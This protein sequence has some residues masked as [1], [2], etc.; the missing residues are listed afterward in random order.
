MGAEL[1]A[2]FVAVVAGASFTASF[3][4]Q[5]RANLRVMTGGDRQGS[6]AV[7]VVRHPDWI[8]GMVLQVVGFGLQALALGIG[9]L[10]VVQTALITE[11][12]FMVPASAWVVQTK[13]VRRDWVGAF[14]VIV[15]LIAFEGLARPRPGLESAPFADWRIPI[16]VC[17]AMFAAL[18]LS[19]E[20]LPSYRA[21]LRGA[22]VGVWG[23]MLGGLVKQLAH[24]VGRGF[25]GLL[26]DW[27][28]WL[29]L[30]VGLVNIL[31]VNL[32]LRA[33]RLESAQATMASIAPLS[34]LF[35][36]AA[37][38]DERL[39]AGPV[40]MAGALS[41]IVLCGIGVALLARSPSL[42]ALGAR[43]E[44]DQADEAVP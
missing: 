7:A 17:V 28:T 32:A 31:W 39:S 21:A 4:L 44:T 19:G 16:L 37:V 1:L 25:G 20:R 8:I 12:V 35:F 23:G 33:G 42:V 30:A 5:Q 18:M 2:I 26:G 36:A 40:A 34:S 13:P 14:F 24:D 15:G 43:L 38:F 22:A 3:A 27:S 9:A 11:F 6:E 10:A 41:G 29:L